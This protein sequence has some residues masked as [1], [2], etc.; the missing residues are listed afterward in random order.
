[1][2]CD[3]VQI[4][5]QTRGQHRNAAS[6][7]SPSTA[8]S[9]SNNEG[10]YY[11]PAIAD[12]SIQYA[13]VHPLSIP[14]YTYPVQQQEQLH[15]TNNEQPKLPTIVAA[16]AAAKT[17][18]SLARKTTVLGKEIVGEGLVSVVKNVRGAA[19]SSGNYTAHTYG[20]H[21]DHRVSAANSKN[22]TQHLD[23][24]DRE[25][26]VVQ[27]NTS[28]EDAQG[29]ITR[30]KEPSSRG[31]SGTR[32]HFFPDTPA[33]KTKADSSL[34]DA[35]SQQNENGILH[36]PLS[37][38][39]PIPS[40]YDEWII[41]PFCQTLCLPTPHQ[42]KKMQQQKL[43]DSSQQSSAGPI[44][45]DRTHVLPSPIGKK[46]RSSPSSMG[47]EA[48]YISPLSSPIASKRSH[49]ELEGENVETTN[50]IP[51]PTVIPS[52]VPWKA[53]PTTYNRDANTEYVYVPILAIRRQRTGEEERYHEDSAVIDLQLSCLDSNGMPPIMPQDDDDED[54]SKPMMQHGN[55]SV[56]LKRSPWTPCLH[57]S[58]HRCHFHPIILVR[59]NVPNGFADLTF[60]AQVLDRF[61]Q[62]NYRDMPFPEEELPMFCYARGSLLKRDKL[63]NLPIPKSFGFVVKNERGDS[64]YGT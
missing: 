48:M 31:S 21:V 35:Q 43:L 9:T 32:Q 61:P 42:L 49:H 20:V 46:G 52:I 63:K 54:E 28:S 38:L 58:L 10:E 29:E 6:V 19:A 13:K 14:N 16:A 45:L 62:K 26:H 7:N 33:P 12:V 4:A 24:T 50:A 39:L 30:W 18:T 36:K 1:M 44:L 51:D 53:V 3:S 2:Q 56:I 55:H 41:P 40:G 27:Q 17:L 22:Q 60:P 11:I 5:H 64:I 34:T 15:E 37:D 23:D 59:R 47:V 25:L 8:D 57:S